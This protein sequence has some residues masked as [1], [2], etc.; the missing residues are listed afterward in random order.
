MQIIYQDFSK[1]EANAWLA[2]NVHFR[3]TH[4]RIWTGCIK[5]LVTAI[6]PLFS[7]YSYGIDLD[8]GIFGQPGD[9]NCGS[10]RKG[11]AKIFGI[12]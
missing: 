10:R 7:F 3:T 12:D 2:N 11:R 8:L 9:L 4:V 1:E 6:L 5:H